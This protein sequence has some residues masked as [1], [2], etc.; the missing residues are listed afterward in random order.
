MNILTRTKYL[1]L[2]SISSGFGGYIG[3]PINYLYEKTND[4]DKANLKMGRESINWNSQYGQLLE[5][6][7]VLTEDEKEFGLL[8]AAFELRNNN[9][10]HRSLIPFGS[11]CALYFLSHKVNQHM[12]LYQKPRTV[13][14]MFILLELR[15]CIFFFCFN[16]SI[17]QIRLLAYTVFGTIIYGMYSV[18]TDGIQIRQDNKVDKSLA[19]LGPGDNEIE[20]PE[21][22]ANF[23]TD[24]K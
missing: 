9:Y 3:I 2:G 19:E 22:C 4:V 14:S 5:K 21:E 17:L 24:E 8:K 7:L 10:I 20:I 12:D 15:K 6:S 11:I 18:L 16:L 13:C 1:L 23:F